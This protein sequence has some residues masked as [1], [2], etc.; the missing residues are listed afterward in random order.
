MKRWKKIFLGIAAIGMVFAFFFVR[1][2]IFGGGSPEH[3]WDIFQT[4]YRSQ[5]Q[6]LSDAVSRHIQVP[7]DV[8]KV[9]QVIEGDALKA[10]NPDFYNQIA[11]GDW[12]LTY[13]TLVVIYRPV[14]D[15]VI[16]TRAIV[17]DP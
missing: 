5:G 3:F 6:L 12:I 11:Y 13:Q 9:T 4:P 17:Q 15:R 10:A 7:P 16:A 14:G 2:R 1:Y 8:P